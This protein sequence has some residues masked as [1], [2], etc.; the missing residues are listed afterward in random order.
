MLLH[1]RKLH[2]LALT[3]WWE[4]HHRSLVVFVGFIQLI[5]AI[6]RECTAL[7]LRVAEMG[8]LFRPCTHN[9]FTQWTQAYTRTH[10]QVNLRQDPSLLEY[11]GDKVFSLWEGAGKMWYLWSLPNINHIAV[12]LACC[13][14]ELVRLSTI[15]TVCTRLSNS[16][17]T[18]SISSSICT[19]NMVFF[20]YRR[21][22]QC[23]H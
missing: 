23:L 5:K 18:T 6:R 17:L 19:I 4:T 7:G 8:N 15:V 9:I 21:F 20:W 14:P 16:T 13:Y 12:M 2:I 10:T 22:F 1:L 11:V 3:C